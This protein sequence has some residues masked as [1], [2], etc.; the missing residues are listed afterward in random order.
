VKVEGKESIPKI[1]HSLLIENTVN[2]LQW[3]C[4]PEGTI[5][6]E[7]LVTKRGFTGATVP[8]ILK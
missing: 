7:L 4:N 1:I 6:S 2:I 3:W 8:V 5:D